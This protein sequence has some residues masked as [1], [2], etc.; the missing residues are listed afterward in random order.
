MPPTTNHAYPTILNKKT[1]F[2]Y[3]TTSAVARSFKKLVMYHV[4]PKRGLVSKDMIY[5]LEIDVYWPQ[6]VTQKKTLRR[7]DVSNRCKVLEDA[8]CDALDIDDSQMWSV[9]IEKKIGEKRTIV[10]LIEKGRLVDMV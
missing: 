6:W 10:R 2:T 9:K 7:A 3:R 5:D 4:K 8:I 1:G